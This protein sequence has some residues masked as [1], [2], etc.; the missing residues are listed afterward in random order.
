MATDFEFP[1]NQQDMEMEASEQEGGGACV[2]GKAWTAG[3][4]RGEWEEE[5]QPVVSQEEKAALDPSAVD[6]TGLEGAAL[7]EACWSM[8]PKAWHS[9]VLRM[10]SAMGHAL[11][12]ALAC[13][14]F[15]HHVRSGEKVW[16]GGLT[17]TL[18]HQ[19]VCKCVCFRFALDEP[20]VQDG[21]WS[22]PRWLKPL[23]ASGHL[24]TLHDLVEYG[25]FFRTTLSKMEAEQRR[26]YVTVSLKNDEDIET[27]WTVEFSTRLRLASGKKALR[28]LGNGSLSLYTI[29]AFPS[30][31]FL[32]DVISK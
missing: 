19:G 7:H 11:A 30:A 28:L 17:P 27:D 18:P 5:T 22:L 1:A 14:L 2:H 3:D 29:L 15:R 23:V 31:P 20:T 25:V 13:C 32:C 6:L 8:L 12:L 10:C 9:F 16:Q 24:A 21:R 26:Q 4:T